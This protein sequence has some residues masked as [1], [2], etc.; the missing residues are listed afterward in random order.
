MESRIPHAKLGFATTA[1]CSTQ[2]EN[3]VQSYTKN[4]Y[5]EDIIFD[6]IWRPNNNLHV[7]PFRA[8]L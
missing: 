8:Q 1:K 2:R 6:D 4:T 5:D 7:K 3:E